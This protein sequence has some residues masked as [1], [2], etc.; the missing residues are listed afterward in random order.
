LQD[1]EHDVCLVLEGTY[2]FITGGVSAWVHNLIRGLPELNFTA[3]SI[4]PSA[5]EEW[6][7]RYELPA[8]FRDMKLLYI[9]DYELQREKKSS[10]RAAASYAAAVRKFHHD[11]KAKDY[12]GFRE[13]FARYESREGYLTAYDNMYGR[14]AWD[15]LMDFYR[16]FNPDAPFIDY[17][18]TYR[19]SHLPIFK[20]LTMDVPRAKVYHTV[21]TGYAGLIG[22]IAKHRHGRPLLLTEHGLYTKERKMEIMT[23]RWIPQEDE[24]YARIRRDMGRFKEFWLRI[25]Q[26][27]G[28]LVYRHA[29]MIT[30]LFEGNRQYE[31]AGGASPETTVVIPNAVDVKAYADLRRHMA[32]DNRGITDEFIIGFVGR[33]VQI[34]DLKTFI[35]AVKIVTL[36]MP[37]VKVEI[38][39]PTNED[40]E[41]YRECRELVA[42]LELEEIITFVG[43]VSMKDYY[44]HLDLIVLTSISEGQPLV[45]LEANAA[46][47][48]VVASDVGACREL[49][50]G[51]T[52]E[53][54]ELGPS[55]IITR[56]ADPAETAQGIVK[57]LADP[58][59]R[60]SMSAAGKM[61]VVH[62][63]TEEKLMDSYRAIYDRLRQK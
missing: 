25:F 31:I 62:F 33:V 3:V 38:I 13:L 19:I 11:L 48:P 6:S 16:H 17:F 20:A 27:I 4:L 29:D 5:K 34:K 47:I 44:P 14:E 23:S 43:S 35:R 8:N 36:R 7:Y 58:V 40:P 21:S 54:R 32:E 9:H 39:G 63:Y 30:T 46:G 2:P 53:D 18:W 1:N 55:G 24:D 15:I 42:L 45:I 49:L 41:Y 50:L 60:R 12:S 10:P 61:R 22:V 28:E 37:R 51:R 52:R 26:S 59:L 56:V 57:I